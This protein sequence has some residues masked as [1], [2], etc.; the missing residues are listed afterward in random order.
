MKAIFLTLLLAASPAFAGSFLTSGI[1]EAAREAVPPGHT[2]KRVTQ[3]TTDR[4]AEVTYLSVMR[5]EEGKVGGFYGSSVAPFDPEEVPGEEN[6]GEEFMAD[7]EAANR[8]VFW[9]QE[10]ESSAGAVLAVVKGKKALI[11]Q[12]KLDRATQEGRFV[13]KYLSNGLFNSY[14]S[15]EFNL[16]KT[17]KGWYIQNA[18][19]GQAV[20]RVKVITHSLGITTLQGLCPN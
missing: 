10:V 13:I 4:D 2:L 5:N 12:G 3:L 20:P 18:Y 7:E 6:P 8:N 14:K 11:L 1:F 15:C 19:N 9:L 16:R 17:G